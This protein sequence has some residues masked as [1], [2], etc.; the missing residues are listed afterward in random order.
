M[1]SLLFWDVKQRRLVVIYVSGQPISPILKGPTSC[2]KT[3]VTNY[4]STLLNIPEEKK[5]HRPL[6]FILSLM[7]PAYSIP[8]S[9][10]NSQLRNILHLRLV[11]IGSLFLPGFSNNT[12][13]ALYCFSE[14][15]M[16]TVLAGVENRMQSLFTV[17]LSSVILRSWKVRNIWR[18]HGK[19]VHRNRV[20]QSAAP[21]IV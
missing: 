7:N 6:V 10:F 2:P 16:W 17:N 8:Y 19:Y 12:L 18:S 14:R 13:H 4:Q 21:R 5:S 3:S 20:G 15:L 11:H 1:K 9:F